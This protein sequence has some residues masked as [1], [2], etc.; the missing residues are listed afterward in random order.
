MEKNISSAKE[1]GIK[2]GAICF[3]CFMIPWLL[4]LIAALTLSEGIDDQIIGFFVGIL[5]FILI[6]SFFGFSMSTKSKVLKII[7][8]ILVAAVPITWII[9]IIYN[10]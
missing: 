7:S 5:I 4:L 3:S 1:K 2:V 10:N 9:L 6:S 8:S